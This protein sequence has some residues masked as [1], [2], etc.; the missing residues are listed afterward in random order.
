MS[1][2]KTLGNIGL[3]LGA[4]AGGYLG[5]D[6]CFDRSFVPPTWE[7]VFSSSKGVVYTKLTI[8]LTGLSAI[9][10]GGLLRHLGRGMGRSI[11]HH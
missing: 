11:D 9:A 4:L 2:E 8:Y 1:L 6:Y 3:V 10:G 7:E 5:L